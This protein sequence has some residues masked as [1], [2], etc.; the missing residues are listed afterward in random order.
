MDIIR[1]ERTTRCYGEKVALDSL[2]LTVKRGEICAFL[3]PNGAGKTTAIRMLVGLL[4][5]TSGRI[6]VADYDTSVSPREVASQLGFVPEEVFLYGKLTGREYLEFIAEVRMLAKTRMVEAIAQQSDIFGLEPFLNELIENYSHGMRQRIAF[7]AALLHDPDLLVVDEP[8]VGLDPRSVRIAKDMLKERATRGKTV[9]MST[10]TLAVAEE[11]A[12]RIGI[13][14]HGKLIF[15]GTQADLR[16]HFS[17]HASLE[18]Y[19]LAMTGGEPSEE[20]IYRDSTFTDADSVS[21]GE[22]V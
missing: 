13:L 4:R 5:P 8:M 16:A 10:H 11:I 17:R 2:D 9:F 1:F 12:D 20:L 15:L 7:A 14:H 22:S 19:F 21:T 6:F 18:H 3:G